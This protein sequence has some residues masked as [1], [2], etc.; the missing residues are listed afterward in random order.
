MILKYFLIAAIAI[1]PATAFAQ[2]APAAQ[3]GAVGGAATGAVGGAIVG[4]PIGAVVGGVGGAVVGAIVGDQIPR[5][6]T[7]VVDQRRPSYT[8]AEPVVVGATLPNEG[9]VYYDVPREYGETH[10]SLHGDQ[11]PHGPGRS[12]VPPRRAGH[13]VSADR[14]THGAGAP[15]AVIPLSGPQS[16]SSD[17]AGL[18]R[19]MRVTRARCRSRRAMAPRHLRH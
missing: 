1:I 10:L 3:G 15:R 18:A 2:N 7:Y 16:R 17:G 9:V 12:P 13:P 11:Q 5:F 19:S 6:Q 4:G 8:Y 14:L